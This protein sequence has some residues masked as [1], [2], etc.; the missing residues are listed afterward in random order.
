MLFYGVSSEGIAVLNEPDIIEGDFRVRG[1]GRWEPL[2]RWLVEMREKWVYDTLRRN[3]GGWLPAE[4]PYWNWYARTFYLIA[5]PLM[6]AGLFFAA[7]W[8]LGLLGLGLRR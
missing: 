2:K 1:E 5:Y 3:F 8:L 4:W 6:V 7:R